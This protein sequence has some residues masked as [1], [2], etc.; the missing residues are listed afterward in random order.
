M[1]V[2]ISENQFPI[3]VLPFVTNDLVIVLSKKE[4]CL[5]MHDA[6][7]RI[8]NR[9]RSF[10]LFISGPSKTAD[11]EQCLVIGAQGAMS[12]TVVITN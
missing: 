7:K 4:L 9:E 10:G 3:R 5:H 1:A 11:I 6:Y 12:L 2:W 8:A